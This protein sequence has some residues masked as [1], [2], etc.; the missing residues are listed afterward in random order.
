MIRKPPARS[1]CFTRL[2]AVVTA[3]KIEESGKSF[4]QQVDKFGDSH[5]EVRALASHP[6][7]YTL[8]HPHLDPDGTTTPSSVVALRLQRG[9]HLCQ[10]YCKDLNALCCRSTL[11]RTTMPL[12]LPRALPLRHRS[13]GTAS[14]CAARLCPAQCPPLD[15][16]WPGAACCELWPQMMAGSWHICKSS[17]SGLVP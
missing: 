13:S 14:R 3:K 15:L 11:S 17:E 5:A 12:R 1:E 7:P 4:G 8:V 10:A 16:S 9:P 6:S 2:L